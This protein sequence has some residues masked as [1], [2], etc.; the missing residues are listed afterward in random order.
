MPVHL[1]YLQRRL[2]EAGGTVEQRRLDA[3]DD[4]GR[5]SVIVNSTGLGSCPLVP[6]PTLRQIRGQH[7]VATKPALTEFVSEDTGPSPIC[8]ASTPNGDTVREFHVDR[9]FGTLVWLLAIQRYVFSK[10]VHCGQS[11]VRVSGRG[12]SGYSFPGMSK[13]PAC[14]PGRSARCAFARP[15]WIFV[16]TSSAETSRGWVVLRNPVGW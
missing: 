4:V 14:P 12:A 5:D 9:A 15:H 7:V 6:D 1:A 11:R 16:Q 2:A 10:Q 3:L 8:C 13:G